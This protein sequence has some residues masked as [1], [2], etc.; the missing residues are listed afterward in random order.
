[1]KSGA[2]FKAR[3]VVPGLRVAPSGLHDMRQSAHVAFARSLCDL[4]ANLRAL[5]ANKNKQ[6]RA[7]EKG[8][9]R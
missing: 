9:I 8:R 6:K 2:A 3:T 5:S 4:P 1:V 7:A